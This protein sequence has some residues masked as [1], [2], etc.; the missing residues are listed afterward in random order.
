MF[1]SAARPLFSFHCERRRDAGS[2]S[3][4]LNFFF[5]TFGIVFK[6]ADENLLID[7]NHLNAT[8]S[9]TF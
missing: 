6:Q 7:T 5:Q 8:L 3:R 2:R 9:G 1:S 4:V